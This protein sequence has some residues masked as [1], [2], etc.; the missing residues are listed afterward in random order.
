[1][2]KWKLCFLTM[3]LVLISL[4]SCSDPKIDISF[5][6]ELGR[7]TTAA[8]D[9]V[10]SSI[11]SKDYYTYDDI[12]NYRWQFREKVQYDF[13]SKP[14]NSRDDIHELLTSTGYTPSEANALIDGIINRGNGLLF[15]SY[16]SYGDFTVWM[17]IET[18]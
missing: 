8:F 12:N 11:P 5:Y 13:S 7:I 1:M 9:N 2:K 15:F 10:V 17:Y 16:D 4:M 18:E 6:F 14:H 3:V